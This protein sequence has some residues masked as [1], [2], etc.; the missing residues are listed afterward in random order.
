[1]NNKMI[2]GINTAQYPNLVM[3]HKCGWG[4]DALACGAE[5]SR[6]V[7]T[8]ILNGNDDLALSEKI[9]LSNYI[10][11]D[12]RVLFV[13]KLSYID[14]RKPKWKLFISKMDVMYQNILK[15]IGDDEKPWCLHFYETIQSLMS[16][17]PR[18]LYVQLLYA[19]RE[20]EIA[21]HDKCYKPRIRTRRIK[22]K[23]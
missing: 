17:S 13:P 11:I 1:M 14:V 9:H 23:C 18:I 15:A 8:D 3:V 19:K 4:V 16:F 10:E 5:V 7:M 2:V 6:E 20:L 22:K 21:Y 12:Y